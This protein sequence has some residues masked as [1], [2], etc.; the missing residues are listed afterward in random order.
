MQLHTT[1]QQLTQQ[2][3]GAAVRQLRG[4][5]DDTEDED[6]VTPA[7]VIEILQVQLKTAQQRVKEQEAE[8][9]D[10]GTS[11]VLR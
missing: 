2:Q 1:Q 7:A 5:D 6:D 9:K 3:S 11:R 4:M 10:Q 8:V